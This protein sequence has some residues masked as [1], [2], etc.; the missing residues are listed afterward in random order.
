MI[1]AVPWR[2]DDEGQALLADVVDPPRRL[3]IRWDHGDRGWFLS[4]RVPGRPQ[5]MGQAAVEERV[6]V[7][8]MPLLV[9]LTLVPRELHEHLVGHV[10]RERR[11]VEAEVWAGLSAGAQLA[12]QGWPQVAQVRESLAASADAAVTLERLALDMA[13]A[14]AWE[15]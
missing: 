3:A 14:D 2:W 5:T 12:P 9:A 1:S 10:E 6:Y 4:V 8:P 7:T 11:L 13:A 15:G